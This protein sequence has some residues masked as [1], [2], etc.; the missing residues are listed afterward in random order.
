MFAHTYKDDGSWHYYSLYVANTANGGGTMSNWTV[1]NN[2]FEVAAAIGRRQ[3]P[4]SPG[5]RATWRLGLHP[6]HDVHAQ[7]RPKCCELGQAH[8]PAASTQSQTAPF[9]SVNPAAN[10]FRP[11]GRIAALNAG[12]PADHVTTD[13]TAKLRGSAPDAGALER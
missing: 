11:D 13:L 7:R 1:R 3:P 9:G 6:G 5:G 10:D 2:T 12:D 8:D 4:A